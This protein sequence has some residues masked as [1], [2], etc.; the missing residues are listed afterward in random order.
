M[1]SLKSGMRQSCP[2]STLLFKIVLEF[3]V[4][5]IWKEEEIKGTQ[6][7]KEIVK[8]SLFVMT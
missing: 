1:I 8:L 7:G 4:R 2:L 6:K 3:L 5:A